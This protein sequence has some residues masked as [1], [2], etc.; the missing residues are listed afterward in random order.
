MADKAIVANGH[1]FADKAVA[2]HPGP[3]TDFDPFLD[4]TERTNENPVTE[5][6][7]IQVGRLYNRHAFACDD[8]TDRCYMAF[9]FSHIR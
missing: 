4:F 2:L 3:G 1:Q 5:P 9:D 7:F 8:I 6:A